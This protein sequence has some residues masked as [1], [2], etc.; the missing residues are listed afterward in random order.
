MLLWFELT[1]LWKS[2]CWYKN[3]VLC[4]WFLLILGNYVFLWLD[5]SKCLKILLKHVFLQSCLLC[6]HITLVNPLNWVPF[7]ALGGIRN[8]NTFLWGI[9]GLDWT[10]VKKQLMS[11]E[12]EDF[13]KIWRIVV[14]DQFKKTKNVWLLGS[15]LQRNKGWLKIFAQ[16]CVISSTLNL[17]T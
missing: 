7:Y 3:T 13:Q 14:Q 10:S 2:P 17:E 1:A 8:Q 9:Q 5:A 12:E 6:V 11:K 4:L 15:K 16:Y